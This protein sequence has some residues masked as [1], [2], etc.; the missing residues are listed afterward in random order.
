MEIATDM[1][2]GHIDVIVLSLLAAKDYYGYDLAKTVKER[3]QGAF[4]IKEAT[5]YLALKRLEKAGFVESYWGDQAAGA[6][7]KYYRIL[8]QGRTQI[9]QLAQQWDLLKNIVDQFVG[10]LVEGKQ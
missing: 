6:R 1:L 4:E 7:R 10:P 8:P 9:A 5:L 3:T 2:R